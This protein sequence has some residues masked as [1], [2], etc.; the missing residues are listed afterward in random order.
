VE[1][2][3]SAEPEQQAEIAVQRKPYSTP[4]MKDFGSVAEVTRARGGFPEY[5][6]GS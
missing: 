6:M 5:F 4:M 1:H 2:P 3:E